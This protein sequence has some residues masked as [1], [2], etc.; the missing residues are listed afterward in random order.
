M[1]TT[2]QLLLSLLVLVFATRPAVAQTPTAPASAATGALTGTVLDSLSRQPVAYATV[3]LLPA[4]GDKA[5]TG[6]AAD[7]AGK[8]SLTKLAAGTFRLRASYVGYGTR[9]R[10]VTVGM[11]PTA[12]G[13]FQLPTAAQAL[14]EAVIIGSK[15]VVEVRADRLVYNADQDVS[16]AGGT[17]QDVLRKAP[18]LAVDGDGNV[19]MR[20]SSNFKVLVNNKPS[21]TLARN[22]AEALKSIPAEQI[23]SVEVITTP[24]AKYDGEGTAGIINIVLKKGVDQGLNGRV[25]AS[26]GNRNSNFNS[27]LNFKKGKVGFTS[28]ASAGAWYNPGDFTRDRRDSSFVGTKFVG[29]NMLNQQGS[30]YNKGGWYYGTVGLDYDPAEHHTFSLAGSANGYSGNTTQNLLNRY[31]SYDPAA[32]QLFLRDTKNVF[33]GLNVEATGTYTRTFATARKEWSTLAQYA[34]NNGT[35][36]YDFDQYNNSTIAL[37]TSQASY[38][39]RS[40]GRTPG[41]E[42]TFQTDFT[43]PFGDKNAL[44]VGLKAIFRRTGSVATVDGLTLT[45]NTDFVPLA[46][47][48]TDFS[49]SQDVQSAYGIYSLGVGKKFTAN[50]GTRLERTAIGAEFR[51]TPTPFEPRSYLTLLPN[52]SARYAFTDANS[53]RFAYSRRITRPFIDY[54]NPFVDRSDAKNITFGNPNLDPELTDSYELSYSTAIKT[55]TINAAASVRHTGNAIEQIR[56]STTNPSVPLP[57]GVPSDPSI[58]AQTFA[59][60]AANTFYQFNVYLSAK[61]LAKMDLS[62]GPDVQYIVRRSPFLGIERRGFTAGINLNVS[63]KFDKGLTVQGFAFGSLPSPEIQGTGSANL[64]YQMGVKKTFMKEKADLSLNIASPFNAYWPY[65]STTTTAAFDERTEN[66]SYQRGFRL[67]FS[68]RFG[69]SGQAKQRK[70]INNDDT[71][72]GASKQGG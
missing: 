1:K 39:E 4:T 21:P 33:S 13:N 52:G 48:A 41:H 14:G 45:Q 32:N 8:F 11:G 56:F 70:S 46:G 12:V 71:K 58:T 31:T 50:L 18:L 17:A 62:A 55:T 57:A 38:R 63:Y 42:V 67:N 59:N 15:P 36:G 72:G 3:V 24:S 61:P 26:S 51:T 64:Y 44:E 28:S 6:V 53:L 65:R 47:R 37:E 9:T 5:I 68:Y 20:G 16:N 2:T 54:L 69:Q 30:T 22:L 7:D 29:I 25:G 40:R 23:Q 35:F 66:R 27:S 10:T 49:Y 19:K 43:Q 60:V 34:L